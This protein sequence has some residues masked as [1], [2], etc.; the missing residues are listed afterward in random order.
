MG[1]EAKTPET[2][3]GEAVSTSG[4]PAIDEAKNKRR[5]IDLQTA[6]YVYERLDRKQSFDAE[7]AEFE[8]LYEEVNY[9]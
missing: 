8:E 7:V 3:L 1:A 4:I 6:K 5:A 9:Y 2:I